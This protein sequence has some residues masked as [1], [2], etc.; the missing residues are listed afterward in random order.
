MLIQTPSGKSLS[1]QPES[2]V[3]ITAGV[4]VYDPATLFI[5]TA[6]NVTVTTSRGQAGVVFKNLPNGSILPVQII[7][8]TAAT[9][10]D[11]VLL[12]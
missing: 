4:T 10:A 11:L 6:G 5:G 2:A 8:V 1:L 3:A 9:A 7:A 12:S